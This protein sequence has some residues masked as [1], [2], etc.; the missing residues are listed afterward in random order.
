MD[1]GLRPAIES[2]FKFCRRVYFEQMTLTIE[3]LKLNR[4]GHAAGFQQQWIPTQ[5][6]IITLDGSD[7]GWLQT[8]QRSDELFL[9]QFFVDGPFQRRGIGTNV[10]GRLIE[11]AAR[12]GLPLRLGVVK[13]NPAVRLYQRLGFRMTDEDDRKFYMRRDHESLGRPNS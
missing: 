7:I 6:Q 1:I 4:E 9:A 11:E 8:I 2:D 10:L 13:S 3:T 12:A 5:V